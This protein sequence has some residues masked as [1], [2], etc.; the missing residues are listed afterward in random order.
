MHIVSS[1]PLTLRQVETLLNE[2]K[3]ESSGTLEYEQANTLEYAEKFAS[4]TAAKEKALV[5]EIQK[6]TP[7]PDNAMAQIVVLLPRN[8]EELKLILAAEKV[9]LPAEQIKEVIK[10]LKKYKKA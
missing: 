10:V 2:R 4:L 1:K 6:V 5:E 7:L 9:E 8:E 3:K